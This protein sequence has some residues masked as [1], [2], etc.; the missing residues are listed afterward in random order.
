VEPA[1]VVRCLCIG[2]EDVLPMHFDAGSRK[3]VV[4]RASLDPELGAR[5]A[6]D[7]LT[8]ART[9]GYDMSSIDWA[10]R[11]GEPRAV[12][13]LNPVPDFD[14]HSL[15]PEYFDWAVDRMATL[16]IRLAKR[17]HPIPEA[18]GWSGLFSTAH[19]HEGPGT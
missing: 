12:D 8:I 14:M 11:D 15:A 9:F 17:P 2:R 5:I 7:T 16:A 3:C 4:A 19:S 13:I 1:H 6:R 10:V 18:P